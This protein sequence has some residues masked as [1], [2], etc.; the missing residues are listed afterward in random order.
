MRIEELK[1][2]EA[3]VP[4]EYKLANLEEVLSGRPGLEGCGCMGPKEYKIFKP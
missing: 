2:M 3:K 1:G 4:R